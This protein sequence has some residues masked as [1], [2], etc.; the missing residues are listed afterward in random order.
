M[1]KCEVKK[2]VINCE[3]ISDFLKININNQNWAKQCSFQELTEGN[4]K[5]S[6]SKRKMNRK[7]HLDA[8][9]ED[10]IF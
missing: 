10:S 6:W 5:L 8:G 9:C 2:G 4:Q 7:A 3:E 1:I